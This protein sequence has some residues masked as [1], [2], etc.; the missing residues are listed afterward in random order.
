MKTNGMIFHADSKCSDK[1]PMT[2]EEM[3]LDHKWKRT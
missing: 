1:G 3:I 2:Y